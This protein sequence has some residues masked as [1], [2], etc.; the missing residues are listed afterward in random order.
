MIRKT[1]S[2]L[3]PLLAVICLAACQPGAAVQT[4]EPPSVE[5]IIDSTVKALES[6]TTFEFEASM[7]MTMSGEVE[8]EP[9]DASMDSQMA[10]MVDVTSEELKMDMD[11][12]MN[13]PGEGEI[14]AGMEMYFI[15]DTMYALTEVPA[16][17]GLSMWVKSE[18]PPGTREQMAQ[19]EDQVDLLAI[20]EV[21]LA[22]TENVEGTD[23]YLLELTTDPDRL[24]E[25]VEQRM[26]TAG[27]EP[28][29]LKEELFIREMVRS[30]SVRQWVEIDTYLLR[31]AEVHMEM[32]T[33][34]TAVDITMVLLARNHGQPVSI[35]LPPEADNAI[36]LPANQIFQ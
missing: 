8:G 18:L 7:T 29:G 27:T 16:L 22:G 33:E 13:V 19:V 5:Q 17:G 24:W 20:S 36:E 30:Y 15:S 1:T 25:L 14:L 3:L 6:V 28:P 11:V 32:E 12:V 34:G 21:T 35:E 2:M 4:A 10:G 26:S 23:C 31:K 9:V